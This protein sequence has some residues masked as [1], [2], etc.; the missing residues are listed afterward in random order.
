[1]AHQQQQQQMWEALS[2]LIS[3]RAQA[4][5]SSVPSFP[6]FD[7]TKE[8]WT[9][10]LGRLEQHF[11]ANRVTDSTQ[12]R[13]YLLSWISSESFELMQKLFGKEALRQQPYECLVTA[14]TDH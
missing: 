6:A 1:M 7:K 5:G 2:L 11:E 10:Y 8:R 3:S 9:T 14:L 13:A 12:K 4:E